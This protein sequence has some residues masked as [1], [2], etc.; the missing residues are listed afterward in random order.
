MNRGKRTHSGARITLYPPWRM[1]GCFIHFSSD[2]AQRGIRSMCAGRQAVPGTGQ[3]SCYRCHPSKHAAL[4]GVAPSASKR[5][6]ADGCGRAHKGGTGYGGQVDPDMIIA[7]CNAGSPG[8]GGLICQSTVT[9]NF[10]V[11][12]NSCL[13]GPD[14]PEILSR[15]VSAISLSLLAGGSRSSSSSVLPRLP[16]LLTRLDL[17]ADDKCR[18]AHAFLA[19]L[20]WRL[21]CL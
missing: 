10:C 18:L 13:R 4:Y 5:V 9:T 1:R 2:S 19:L 3:P 6:V 16:D 21:P 12:V 11:L 7:F 17:A 20:S 8:K 15:F 14:V